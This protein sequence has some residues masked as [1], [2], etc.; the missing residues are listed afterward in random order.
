MQKGQIL[1][2]VIVGTLII[3]V[4]GGAYFLGRSTSPKPSATPTVISQTPQ[5][6]PSPSPSPVPSTT[7]TV[8]KTDGNGTYTDI[9]A[10]FTFKYPVKWKESDMSNINFGSPIL[11]SL[12]HI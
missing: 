7:T 11:L 10:G 4:A 5:P 8:S 9:S 6:I 1:I 3:V 2:W 12:I